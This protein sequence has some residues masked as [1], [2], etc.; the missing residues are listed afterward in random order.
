MGVEARAQQRGDHCMRRTYGI[1]LEMHTW[2][3][4]CEDQA[5]RLRPSGPPHRRLSNT[6]TVASRLWAGL[7]TSPPIRP[8]VSCGS[9]RFVAGAVQFWVPELGIAPRIHIP[10]EVVRAATRPNIS[11]N[12][13]NAVYAILVPSL[14]RNISSPEVPF[15]ER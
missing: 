10:Q 8:K 15:L 1:M 6:I 13:Y 11:A 12:D 2:F 9:K 4:K 5:P 14:R 7:L 3:P